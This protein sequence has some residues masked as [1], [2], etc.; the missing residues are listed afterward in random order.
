MGL[1]AGAHTCNPRTLGGWDG[2]VIWCVRS[3]RLAWST[4]WN[5]LSTKNTKISWAWWYTPVIVAT[6]KAEEENC[7][8]P[9]GRSY[10]EL[11]SCHCTPAWVTRV[12]LWLKKKKVFSREK[13]FDVYIFLN[14]FVLSFG[15]K[16]DR[17]VIW[18]NQFEWG[19]HWTHKDLKLG[20]EKKLVR[21]F[22]YSPRFFQYYGQRIHTT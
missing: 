9:G 6:Q 18:P 2:W 5:P 14:G 15:S 22:F 3:L 4:W 10:S 13:Y 11:R 1:G 8:N 19:H 12:K 7:M 21:E 20:K 17:T 16:T